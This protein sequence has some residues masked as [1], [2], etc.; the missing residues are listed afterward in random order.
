MR[1]S[2]FRRLFNLWPPFLCN[3]MRLQRLSDD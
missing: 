1:A 2:T 3:S